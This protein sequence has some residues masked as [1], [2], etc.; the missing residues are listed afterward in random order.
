MQQ[1]Y[2]IEP[3]S[4]KR[5]NDW[6]GFFKSRAFVDNPMWGSCY[7]THFHI[8]IDGSG[9]PEGMT[10]RNF[11]I[12]LIETGQMQ[13]YLAYS[14]EGIVVGWCNANDRQAFPALG[15]STSDENIDGN[16]PQGG[17]RSGLTVRD[18]GAAQAGA[19]AGAAQAGAQA[20]AAQAGTQAGAAEKI[21]TVVCFVI[22]PA[23]R[24]KGVATGLLQRVIADAKAEGFSMVEAYP[25]LRA[26]SE[27]GNFRGPLSLYQKNGFTIE[28]RGRRKAAIKV[29]N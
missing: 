24:R 5:L 8:G 20:G 29:F 16:D 7:C 3:L 4:R 11:A 15:P 13:G 27:A 17:A 28:K 2:S 10:N 14:P 6:L 1:T 21:K 19:Q 9:K 18:A 26:K 23:H 25:S 12:R 22:E